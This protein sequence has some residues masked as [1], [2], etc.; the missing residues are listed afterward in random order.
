MRALVIMALVFL[1]AQFQDARADHY[2][3][4]QKYAL[5]VVC[6]MTDGAG[7]FKAKGLESSPE[8]SRIYCRCFIES[9]EDQIPFADFTDSSRI[10]SDLAAG[11]PLTDEQKARVERLHT[12]QV[13]NQRRCGCYITAAQHA[14]KYPEPL[15]YVPFCP[16]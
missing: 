2:S 14:P 12:I 11:K 3:H 1:L 8:A 10:R 5:E 7:A 6:Y 13:V 4:E 16:G 15:Q 9:M